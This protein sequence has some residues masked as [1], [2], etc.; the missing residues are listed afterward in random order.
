MYRSWCAIAAADPKRPQGG[1]NSKTDF[2]A[3]I[4]EQRRLRIFRTKKIKTTL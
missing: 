1:A 4:A 2:P 3:D